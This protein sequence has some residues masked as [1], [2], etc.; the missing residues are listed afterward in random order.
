MTYWSIIGMTA[1]PPH[2]TAERHWRLMRR[3]L[4]EAEWVA[5]GLRSAHMSLQE[6]GHTRRVMAARP[7]TKRA[8]PAELRS[9]TAGLDQQGRLPFLGGLGLH[10]NFVHVDVR[11]RPGSIRAND[12]QLALWSASRT[13]NIA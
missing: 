6:Y 8:V 2:L 4:S 11:P 3:R 7:E 12:G 13:S 5:R 9:I 10:P 1:D